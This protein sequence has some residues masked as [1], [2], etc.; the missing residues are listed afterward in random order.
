MSTALPPSDDDRPTEGESA[1]A[2]P[3]AP[4][5]PRRAPRASTGTGAGRTTASRSTPRKTASTTAG[6]TPAGTGGAVPAD[7]TSEPSAVKA[8]T[9]RKSTAAKAAGASTS[10]AAKKPTTPRTRRTAAKPPAI[11]PEGEAPGIMDAALGARE[12]LA[13]ASK[14][15]ATSADTSSSP[16]EPLTE[17]DVATTKRLPTAEEVYAG[18][19]AAGDAAGDTTGAAVES[20]TTIVPPEPAESSEPVQPAESSEPVQPVAATGPDVSGFE[21]APDEAATT[22]AGTTPAA[23]TAAE[24]TA[25]TERLE[26]VGSTA[27]TTAAPTAAAESRPGTPPGA[28]GRTV[29]DLADRLDDSRFFSSL[30][31]FTFTNYVTR[32]LAGPVYVVGLVLIG[33]GIVVGFANSLSSAIATHAPIGAFV[34]LFGVLITLVGAMLA[35]L[36]L[37]VGIEVF[38]AI[39]EIAQNTRRRRPPNE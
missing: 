19:P 23:T 1:E 11:A 32:K 8:T 28:H 2:T 3:A 18:T 37:R 31:D 15:A 29:N 16:V 24:S 22:A 20:E 6:E 25:A 39:I 33:L 21:S 17:T 4:E 12:P 38:C 34:F 36:L 13:G 9:T 30:F 35:V 14:T 26:P 5:K 10:G 27:P 7:G